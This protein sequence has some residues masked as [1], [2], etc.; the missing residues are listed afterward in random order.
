MKEIV[1]TSANFHA[2]LIEGTLS[3][4]IEVG[5]TISEPSYKLACDGVI[6]D[7]V[8]E[9]VR[10]STSPETLRKMA[11]GLVKFA[12][13]CQAEFDKATRKEEA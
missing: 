2:V 12:D 3:P 4:E 5:I 11:D 7:R 10:F 1:T 6:K 9:T 13:D 8:F